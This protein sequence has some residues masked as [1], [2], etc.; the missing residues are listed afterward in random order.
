MDE[1]LEKALEFSNYRTTIE[2]QRANLRRRFDAMLIVHRENASFNADA[3]TIGLVKALIDTG[4][5]E[6]VLLDTKE[7]PVEINKLD[8]FLLNLIEAYHCA[9]NEFIVE[10]RKLARARNIKKA[11]NW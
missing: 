9:T 11:M 7:N 10:H 4:T 3:Q 1:R 8:V 6:A 5:N 2:N